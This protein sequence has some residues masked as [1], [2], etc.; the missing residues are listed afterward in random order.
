MFRTF[1]K[2]SPPRRTADAPADTSRGRPDGAFA[3]DTKVVTRGGRPII[4]FTDIF[5]RITD[6]GPARRNIPRRN[7]IFA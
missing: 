6:R 3:A 2:N 1:K 4:R 7:I 5:T